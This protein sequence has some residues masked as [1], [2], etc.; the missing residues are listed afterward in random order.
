MTWNENYVYSNK[1][2]KAIADCYECLYED[3]L[4]VRNGECLKPSFSVI[5]WKVDFDSALSSLGRKFVFKNGDFKNYK[6]YNRFQRSVIADI[7]HIDDNTLFEVYHFRCSQRLREIS[8]SKMKR[9][10]NGES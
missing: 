5:D 3:G 8:Y 1:I 4:E 10:L 7:F 9:F 6:F 2:L